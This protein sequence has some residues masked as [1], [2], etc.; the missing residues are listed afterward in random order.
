M[1]LYW[2]P[3][4]QALEQQIQS[5]DKLLLIISPF[6]K[7][8]A[9]DRLISADSLH[10]QVKVIVRWQPSDII[11]SVSDLSIYPQ[12]ESLG[13]P[14]YRHENI[15]LKLFVFESNIAFHASSNLTGRG[16]GYSD[17][18]NVE[19][20][21][22]IEMSDSDWSNI[23][24]LIG[25]SRLV[26]ESLYAQFEEFERNNKLPQASAAA[27]DLGESDPE[28][29]STSSFPAVKSPEEFMTWYISGV[30]RNDPDAVR[31]FIHDI[32]LYSISSSLDEAELEENLRASFTTQPFVLGVV[33]LI[34]EKG[35]IKFGGINDWIHSHCADVPLPYKW[36]I[37]DT[38]NTLYNWLAYFFEE[39]TWD[40]PGARS[41]V[42]YWRSNVD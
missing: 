8:G 40:I 1:G 18:G 33:D 7:Y 24:T 10:D 2:S 15:H 4:H 3:I 14:L 31:R 28:P 12:L 5:G 35:S 17:Q 21:C 29:F 19:I 37:K 25:Q 6:I 11:N 38:T 26:N 34:R 27:L 22:F 30:D 13:V 32:G 39:I 36:E 9:L 20:G 23:Y 16:F 42:V 41:Q